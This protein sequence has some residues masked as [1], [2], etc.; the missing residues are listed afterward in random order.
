MTVDE[1]REELPQL[2]DLDIRAALAYAAEALQQDDRVP[3]R[4][5]E[6]DRG[7]DPLPGFV[8]KVSHGTL[9]RRIDE[10]LYGG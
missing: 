3:V 5:Q 10:E 2:S 7:Q 8:G 6:Q 9:A 4:V 1:I